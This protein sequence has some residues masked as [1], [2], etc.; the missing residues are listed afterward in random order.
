MFTENQIVDFVVEHLK[1]LNHTIN[2]ALTT[3]QK[4]IDIISTSLEGTKY[5]IEAKGGTSAKQD[6]ANFGKTFSN[7]Q[8][9][10]HIAR[11][12][13]KCFQNYENHKDENHYIG[14]A[15]PKD[16]EHMIILSSIKSSLIKSN[17]HVI[18]IEEDRSI[19]YYI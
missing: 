3:K 2:Q 13:I 7:A 9:Y 16:R 6:S 14:M 1:T 15:L 17:I 18:L 19:E 4:G 5:Y 11:A 8:V 10:S 12:I